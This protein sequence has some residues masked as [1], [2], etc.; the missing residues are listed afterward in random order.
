MKRCTQCQ[1]V[2]VDDSKFCT[3]CGSPLP[4]SVNTLPP[5]V[6]TAPFVSTAAATR[7][8]TSTGPFILAAIGFFVWGLGNLPFVDNEIY[9]HETWV[10]LSYGAML[11]GGVLVAVG[12]LIAQSQ[13]SRLIGSGAT[14]L[15]VIGFGLLG[16][17]NL[18]LVISLNTSL[19]DRGLFIGS[20]AGY[21]LLGV[22]VLIAIPNV[23]RRPSRF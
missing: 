2:N 1:S 8:L 14:T 9:F 10:K 3:G 19:G 21:I 16:L 13:L 11:V 7:T 5:P 23:V 12:I 6:Q 20:A 22:A 15:A 17:S 4:I 18:P